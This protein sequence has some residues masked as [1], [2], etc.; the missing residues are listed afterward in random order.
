[1]FAHPTAGEKMIPDYPVHSVKPQPGPGRVLRWMEVP[2]KSGFEEP[3]GPRQHHE[4]VKD[5]IVKD[6]GYKN[7][8]TDQEQVVE[9]TYRPGKCQ[10]P[11][12]V[13]ALRKNLSAGV[14]F[15]NAVP[16]H[17]CLGFSWEESI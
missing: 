7:F 2:H 13:V 3:R 12:R 15:H 11:Y 1:M 5:Y 14:V 10:H 16:K 8:R 4:N 9:F 6:R 17:A